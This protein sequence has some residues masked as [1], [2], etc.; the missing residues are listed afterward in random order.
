MKQT[1]DEVEYQYLI[2]KVA[3]AELRIKEQEAEIRILKK[4]INKNG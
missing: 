2:A 3:A 1:I 4:Q